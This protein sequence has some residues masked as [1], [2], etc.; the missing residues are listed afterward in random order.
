MM[1]V[2]SKGFRIGFWIGLIGSASLL[3]YFVIVFLFN[4]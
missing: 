3:G 2:R 1:D 4:K